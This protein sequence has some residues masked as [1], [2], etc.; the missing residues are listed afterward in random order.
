VL[1][2]LQTTTEEIDDRS[3][4]ALTLVLLVGFVVS[5]VAL[6]YLL[7]RRGE[8]TTE[9]RPQ[10]RESDRPASLAPPPL[11]HPRIEP[12]TFAASAPSTP[13]WLSGVTFPQSSHGVSEAVAC[14][15]LLLEARRSRDLA[16]GIALYSPAFRSRLAAVLGVTEERLVE[17]LEGASFEG[18]AP[19]L[20]S[21]ELVSANPEALNVR[22]GYAD[23]S[24][25]TYRLVWI[26]GRWTIDSIERA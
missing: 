16:A 25:E 20:R 9:E 15:E 5:M 19:A 2:A 8:S 7:A 1:L 21:I 3:L 13:A 10:H 26:G 23:R 17:S 6:S 12:V 11:A 24:A 18:E 14:V 22:A 4:D